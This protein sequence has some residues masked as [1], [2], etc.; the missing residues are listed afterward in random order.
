MHRCPTPGS[1]AAHTGQRHCDSL[2]RVAVHLQ[3][4]I[5]ASAALKGERS[6]RVASA[7][8]EQGKGGFAPSD[9]RP[10][11]EV[12][13]RAPLITGRMS[14]SAVFELA[15]LPSDEFCSGSVDPG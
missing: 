1:A 7:G 4:M 10:V 2:K 14:T 5:E 15:R 13:A 3:A 6:A 12:R 8:W 11:D 9:E